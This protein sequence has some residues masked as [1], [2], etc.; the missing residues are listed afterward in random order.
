MPIDFACTGCQKTL[1]VGDDTAGKQA[2]CPQCGTV[3]QV[4]LGSTNSPAGFAPPP[5]APGAPAF[6]PYQAPQASAGFAATGSAQ[7]ELASLGDRF[8]GALADGFIGVFFVGPGYALMFLDNNPNDPGPLFMGGIAAVVV[9]A[10]AMLGLQIYFLATSS[11]TIGKKIVG[12]QM[13]MEATGVRAGLVNTILLRG[14][15]NGIIGAIPCIGPIYSLADILFIFGADRRCLHDRI[16][17]T[18]V[19]K[20]PN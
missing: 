8:L 1:R 10:L 15:V 14:F 16:A 9:G 12:T 17:G 13:V 7:H 2:K 20:K 18:I 4:P 11:Q 5:P 19:I 6:N 3:L